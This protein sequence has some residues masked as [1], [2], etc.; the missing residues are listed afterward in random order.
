MST[1][2]ANRLSID[3]QHD[4]KASDDLE[5]IRLHDAIRSLKEEVES[6]SSVKTEL[7]EASEQ[8]HELRHAA[9]EFVSFSSFPRPNVSTQSNRL[10]KGEISGKEAKI[11]ELESVKKRL[12]TEL[13]T[14]Q[15][16]RDQLEE[17]SQAQVRSIEEAQLRSK[18]LQLEQ[19]SREIQQQ[20]QQASVEVIHLK[21]EL[22]D[23]E[24]S[25]AD[26]VKV[27]ALSK[28]RDS[29]LEHS[30]VLQ[31]EKDELEKKLY[32]AEVLLFSLSLSS[33]VK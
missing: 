5:M 33:F 20:A 12:S 29:L 14:L 23:R 27:A 19:A 28:E 11:K 26:N 9:I 31:T 22:Q 4:A 6:L 7:D 32:L 15:T 16:E 17:N 8:I 2:N 25:R 13:A 3:Q 21:R 1:N 30:R 10:Q 18:Y 24:E